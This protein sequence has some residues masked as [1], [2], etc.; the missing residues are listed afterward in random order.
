[1]GGTIEKVEGN[2]V[3]LNTP[4]G[5]LLATISDETIIQ[6]TT[7]V[8]T[9]ELVEGVRI[10]VVGA[11]GEDGI[12]EARLISLVPDGQ[13]GFLGGGGF[14]GGGGSSSGDGPQ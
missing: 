8:P 5:S 10:T 3:T 9:A 6:K 7:E 13:E 4:Q 1:M 11:R 14:R 12:V 2:T